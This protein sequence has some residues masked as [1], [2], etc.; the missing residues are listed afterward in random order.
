MNEVEQNFKFKIQ[1]VASIPTFKLSNKKKTTIKYYENT[2]TALSRSQDTV[3][4]FSSDWKCVIIIFLK[5]FS[6]IF[7]EQFV[8]LKKYDKDIELLS[9]ALLPKVLVVFDFT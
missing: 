2:I 7:F 3:I 9:S 5:M 6:T 4:G 1:L 8:T